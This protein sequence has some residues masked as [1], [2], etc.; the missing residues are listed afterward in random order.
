MIEDYKELTKILLQKEKKKD[1]DGNNM[2]MISK[3]ESWNM[4]VGDK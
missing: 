4:N 2:G 3:R 1:G